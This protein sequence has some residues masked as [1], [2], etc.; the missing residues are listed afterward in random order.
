MLEAQPPRPAAARRHNSTCIAQ[1]GAKVPRVRSWTAGVV[2]N[3]RRRQ[4]FRAGVAHREVALV[5]TS[6]RVAPRP[7]RPHQ[8]ATSTSRAAIV[9][10]GHVRCRC[11]PSSVQY[12]SVGL[13]RTIQSGCERVS[14]APHSGQHGRAAAIVASSGIA[15][16][17]G[18]D[19][20]EGAATARA[21][22]A[23]DVATGGVGVG[24]CGLD[25][26]PLGAVDV[27]A[28]RARVFVHQL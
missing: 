9:S 17:I 12:H 23:L 13:G 7:D 4:P 3:R 16:L 5:A 24:L 27:G 18:V 26:R 15:A 25:R 11:W 10:S 20:D 8:A 19:G 2:G 21:A 22:L 6:Q 1:L 14:L 28:R